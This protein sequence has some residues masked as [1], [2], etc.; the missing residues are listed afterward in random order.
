MRIFIYEFVTGGGWYDVD[1]EHPPSGSLLA[2][3]RGMV[4]A[5]ARDFL[6]IKGME[7]ATLH[8]ARL[9]YRPP[10]SKYCLHHVRS[11]CEGKTTFLEQAAVSD[12]TLIIAPEFNYHLDRRCKAAEPLGKRL[13][14]PNADFIGVAQDKSCCWN[15]LRD[16]AVPV[17]QTWLSGYFP[18]DS[19][20]PLVIKPSIGCG[21][22]GVQLAVSKEHAIDWSEYPDG[23]V[24][25]QEFCP[26]LS[27]SVAL[28]CGP[29]RNYPLPACRQNLSTDN[30][31]R[32]LGGD[33]PLSTRLN[34]RAQRLARMA[35]EALPPATGYVGVDLILGDAED[36]SQDYVI[37]INP[38]LTTSYVG[39]RALSN[40]NLAQAMLDVAQGREPQLNWK[41][42]RVRW[43]A[44]GVV[45]YVEP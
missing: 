26:G 41:P 17:P 44:D 18:P 1:P 3:G 27:A 28:L 24:I 5:V 16:K 34:L 7:V 14:S 11:R 37:E 30:R 25:C 12:Y 8:D 39:L 31:F 29:A 19:R 40:T 9:S 22:M 6:A 43:S 33:C 32:Y 42:G 23:E 15:E 45:E 38:R 36:G 13:L 21:S 35:I 20:Y 10:A 2:E 4:E